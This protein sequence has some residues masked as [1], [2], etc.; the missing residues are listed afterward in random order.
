MPHAKNKELWSFDDGET[1]KAAANLHRTSVADLLVPCAHAGNQDQ[2][3]HDG[4]VDIHR[5]MRRE[6]AANIRKV[7]RNVYPLIVARDT[8]PEKDRLDVGRQGLGGIYTLYLETGETHTIQPTPREYER[9][10]CLSHIPLG[11]FS[12]LSPYFSE[13]GARTWA[14]KLASFG[15]QI[16][17]ALEKL[18]MR[19]SKTDPV[20]DISRRILSMSDEFTQNTLS[21]GNPTAESLES[22]ARAVRPAIRDAMDIAAKLQIDACMT[23]LL[24]WKRDLGQ[25]AWRQLHVL[26]TTIWPVSEHSPRWQMFRTIMHPDTVG[27]HLIVGEGIRT[28]EDARDLVGRIVA[29]RLA[30]RLILGTEDERGQRMTQCISSRT[31]V[32][33]DSAYKALQEMYD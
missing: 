21:N 17:G 14:P 25:E 1:F 8:Q 33:A 13:H 5:T 3:L 4:I 9:L 28:D 10:K 6:Y 18:P 26:V 31:D 23:A 19:S 30:A 20:D 27:T 12:I 15:E 7:G 24:R 16:A 2:A 22:Y 11:L 32:V 29:D